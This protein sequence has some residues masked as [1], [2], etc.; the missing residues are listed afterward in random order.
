MVR[1][2]SS[3]TDQGAASGAAKIFNLCADQPDEF[4]AQISDGAAE[5]VQDPNFELMAG[6]F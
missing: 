1:S 2:R 6:C 4:R 3:V 5:A